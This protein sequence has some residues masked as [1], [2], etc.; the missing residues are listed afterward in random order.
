MAQ[1][2]MNNEFLTVPQAAQRLGYSIAW[3]RRL[4]QQGRIQAVKVG[5]DWLVPES[6]LDDF[7]PRKI[8]RPKLTQ[9]EQDELVSPAM[10]QIALGRA[11]E[12]K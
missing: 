11:V 10:K 4:C 9:E 3:V 8:G 2:A 5:R 6:T 12:P 1:P 7:K